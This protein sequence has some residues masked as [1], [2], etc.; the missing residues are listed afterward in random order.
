MPVRKRLLCR[1]ATGLW[2]VVLLLALP[3]MPA[4]TRP[5][6][7]VQADRTATATTVLLTATT[8]PSTWTP[9]PAST[10]R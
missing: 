4:C 8:W 6:P 7:I 3:A 10:V 1:L 5:T 9:A 2:T